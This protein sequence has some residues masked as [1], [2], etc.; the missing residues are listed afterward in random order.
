[1]AT[2]LRRRGMLAGVLILGI[3][4]LHVSSSSAT[5]LRSPRPSTAAPIV[6]APAPTPQSPPPAVD[7]PARPPAQPVV[8]P[9]AFSAP[10]GVW[11]VRQPRRGER[12]TAGATLPAIPAASRARTVSVRIGGRPPVPYLTNA[13]TVGELLGA[14]HVRVAPTDEIRP[15]PAGPLRAGE[16]VVVVRIRRVVRTVRVPALFHTVYEYSPLLTP[17]TQ[18]LLRRGTTGEVSRTVVLTYRNGRR[19]S[20]TVA[21]HRTLVRAVPE[22]VL[23]G[24]GTTAGHGGAI[25]EASWYT[26]CTG[27]T[28]ASPWLPYGT[29]VTITNLADGRSIRVVIDDHGPWGVQGRILD[30]CEP[31]F[32]RI[33]PLAQGVAEV[34]VGW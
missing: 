5:G 33:A 34:R 15:D 8:V 21:G 18:R 12:V 2:T 30:I 23:E 9:V 19:V 17:G 26:M 13:A 25:G 4:L 1:M 10:P 24:P 11:A 28:A 32:Q 31:A 27:M 20:R 14:M 16:R 3:G 29:V 22:V 6:P 7:P